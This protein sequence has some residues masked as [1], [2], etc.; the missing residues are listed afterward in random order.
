MENFWLYQGWIWA[1]SLLMIW[2]TQRFFWQR[3]AKPKARSGLILTGFLSFG[4]GGTPAVMA[5]HALAIGE[6][7]CRRCS[8]GVFTVADAPLAYWLTVAFMYL[9]AIMFL[10]GLAFSVHAF[11]RWS[12]Y[13]P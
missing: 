12:R 3:Y 10:S 9:A 2:A 13:A 8:A 1:A 6:A 5:W 4:L 11:V 7:P